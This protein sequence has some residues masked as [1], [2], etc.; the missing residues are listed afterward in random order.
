MTKIFCPE[1]FHYCEIDTN[2]D[3]FVCCSSWC[4]EYAIGN[5]FEESLYE[6]WNSSNK[7]KKGIFV[8]QFEKQK[9]DYCNTDVCLHHRIVSDDAFEKLYY[10]SKNKNQ[11]KKLRLNFDRT[12]NIKC[13]F[14]RKEYMAEVKENEGF[15]EK[16][17]EEI[18]KTL[19]YLNEC[20][21]MLSVCGVGEF[22]CSKLHTDLIK[23]IVEK[24][25]KINFSFVTNGILCSKENLEKLNLQDRTE[26]MEVSVNAFTEQTYNK[27]CVGGNFKKVQ[28]N[29][30]YISQLKKEDKIKFFFMNFVIT[31]ENYREMPDFVK[32]AAD[33]GAIPQFLMLMDFGNYTDKQLFD[34]LNV[35]DPKHKEHEDFVKVLKNPVFKTHKVNISQNLLEL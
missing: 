24:Y 21:T 12:C 4:R 34:S 26:V 3:V 20:H 31:S 9:F 30:K 5:L 33:L 16:I 25:P 7:G 13:V 2:G 28:E 8:R 11:L 29:L 27:L 22:L 19:P 14:C 10:E 32:W 18:F 15:I 6:I 23:E 1:P 17:F 35:A